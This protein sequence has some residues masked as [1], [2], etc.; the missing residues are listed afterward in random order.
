MSWVFVAAFAAAFAVAS[1]AADPPSGRA[2]AKIV[3]ANV[4]EMKLAP[5]R[6]AVEAV[7]PK[8]DTKDN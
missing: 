6:H 2:D 1:A 4:P 3:V 5:G 7:P 8:N